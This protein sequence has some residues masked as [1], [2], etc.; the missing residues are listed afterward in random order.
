MQSN[1]DTELAAQETL[2]FTWKA[3]NYAA[4]ALWLILGFCGHTKTMLFLLTCQGFA[5]LYFWPPMRAELARRAKIVAFKQQTANLYVFSRYPEDETIARTFQEAV[6]FLAE[7]GNKHEVRV[8]MMLF[9]DVQ[10]I[11]AWHDAAGRRQ[12]NTAWRLPGS[13]FE[14]WE[15]YQAA[16]EVFQKEDSDKR[17]RD[18]RKDG[19]G[20]DWVNRHIF[21]QEYGSAES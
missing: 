11:T 14:T 15:E 8:N 1:Y 9:Q 3:G 12:S 16:C 2:V 13:T 21:N 5:Y 10:V 17:I 20:A 7:T 19:K 18:F 4:L 6:A